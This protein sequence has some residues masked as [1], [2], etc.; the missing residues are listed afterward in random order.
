MVK[1]NLTLKYPNALFKGIGTQFEH[2][3]HLVIK[4]RNVEILTLPENEAF[5]QLQKH[6][7]NFYE[8]EAYPGPKNYTTR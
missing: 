8:N 3:Y 4:S 2:P 1:T 5:F 6:C 7:L